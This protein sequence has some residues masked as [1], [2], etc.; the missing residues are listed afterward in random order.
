MYTGSLG[1]INI[2]D[3]S[4]EW[5]NILLDG[6][7][8]VDKSD[9]LFSKE[10]LLGLSHRWGIEAEAGHLIETGFKTIVPNGDGT[11]QVGP[12]EIIEVDKEKIK[13]TKSVDKHFRN[14]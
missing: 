8:M 3:I 11:Y 1:R 14:K 4:N 6:L 2:K 10:Y 7:N 13:F 9:G 5:K 12:T